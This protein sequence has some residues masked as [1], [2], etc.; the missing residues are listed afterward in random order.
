LAFQSLDDA[1]ELALWHVTVALHNDDTERGVDRRPA[2]RVVP[3][4]RPLHRIGKGSS[5]AE[6][7]DTYVNPATSAPDHTRLLERANGP[8][9]S[10]HQGSQ[11]WHH[12]DARRDRRAIRSKGT[13]PLG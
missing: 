1:N 13:V 7:S 6:S 3:G 10:R 11:P 9:G 2:D 5:L 4:Q 8:L 12:Q